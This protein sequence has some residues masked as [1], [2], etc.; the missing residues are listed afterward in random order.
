MHIFVS[1]PLD[2]L[3]SENAIL[4]NVRK[5]LGS[6]GKDC[7]LLT[8]PTIENESIDCLFDAEERVLALE[9]LLEDVMHKYIAAYETL[10]PEPISDTVLFGKTFDHFIKSFRWD[11]IKYP[12][13]SKMSSI[14]GRMEEEVAESIEALKSKE[15]IS[16]EE[17]KKKEAISNKTEDLH[18]YDVDIDELEYEEKEKVSTPFFKKYYIG[19]LGKLREKEIETL[20]EIEGLFIESRALVKKCA[21][22][23]IYEALGKIDMEKELINTIEKN[24]FIVKK[25][26]YSEEE[27]RKNKEKKEEVE[28]HIKEI[29]TSFKEMIQGRLSRMH[30]LLLHVK[31][32]GLYIESVL[33][34]GLPSMFCIFIMENRNMVKVMQK[35][36]KIASTWKYSNRI[37]SSE[38]TPAGKSSKSGYDF[39][40]KTVTGCGMQA[41]NRE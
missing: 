12:L 25:H 28:A 8:L 23:E 7:D 33:R 14:L 37:S 16:A 1:F 27:Y 36:K 15:S 39:V 2:D 3:V 10:T 5:G 34:Y 13:S 30:T 32:I 11:S 38:K 31:H 26:K 19:V 17:I 40:Y 41:D 4:S 21:D 20:S 9:R 29:E 24:G 35:W 18:I 22:G 6:L